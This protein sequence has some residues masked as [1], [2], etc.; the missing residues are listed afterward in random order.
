MSWGYKIIL[1]YALFVC[2]IAYLVI[3]SSRQNID[4]VT[5]EYYAAEL[6]FQDKI[7]EQANVAKLSAPVTVVYRNDTLTLSFPQEFMKKPLKGTLVV[8]YPADKKKDISAGFETDK[9]VCN[10]PMQQKLYGQHEV[11]VAWKAAGVDYYFEKKI[12]F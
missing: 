2:G 12:F 7:D 1:V 9:A 11:H 6:K 3:R 4:L 5:L 10:I 8:Y